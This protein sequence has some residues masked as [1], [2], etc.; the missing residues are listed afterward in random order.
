M[1]LYKRAAIC[2]LLASLGTL[3]GCII[4]DRGYGH[5]GDRGDHHDHRDEGDRH[6]DHDS[7]DDHHGSDHR[8]EH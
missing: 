7:D 1:N 5:G 4:D 2:V 6:D 3:S 8:F